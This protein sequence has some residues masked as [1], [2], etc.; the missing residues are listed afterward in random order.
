[1]VNLAKYSLLSL[2]TQLPF[3]LLSKYVIFKNANYPI[4]CILQRI[5][6]KNAKVSEV[7]IMLEV[8]AGED[9]Y[10]IDYYCAL[11][12]NV[13]ADFFCVSSFKLVSYLTL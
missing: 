9:P 10:I 13:S 4:S 2:K 1:M 8:C 5:P 11:F 6:R 7:K 3:P 12:D